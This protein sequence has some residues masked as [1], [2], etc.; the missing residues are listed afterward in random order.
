MREGWKIF[1]RLGIFFTNGF[2]F[3]LRSKSWDLGM[4]IYVIG[5]LQRDKIPTNK[6]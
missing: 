5:S 3:F 4:G 2:L 1:R 6:W